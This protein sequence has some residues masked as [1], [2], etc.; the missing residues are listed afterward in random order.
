MLCPIEDN[1]HKYHRNLY[2]C[3]QV[4]VKVIKKKDV[5]KKEY[6]RKNMR[7]EAAMLQRLHHPNIVQ[8]YEVLETDRSYYMVI[9]LAEGSLGDY[10]ADRCAAVLCFKIDTF[11]RSYMYW[12]SCA[13]LDV[14]SFVEFVLSIAIAS[15][16]NFQF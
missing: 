9:E 11:F 14:I 4:A 7:R 10:L 1:L 15:V 5:N 12:V 2:M 3:R 13:L 8:L 16:E 6:L